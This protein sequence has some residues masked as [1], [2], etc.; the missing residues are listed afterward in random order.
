MRR[1]RAGVLGR[2]VDLQLLAHK[3]DVVEVEQRRGFLHGA[4]FH[5]GKVAGYAGVDDGTAGLK[6]EAHFFHGVAEEVLEDDVSHV[7]ACVAD[8][9][10][11]ALFVYLSVTP[12]RGVFIFVNANVTRLTGHFPLG[13]FVS[14][15]MNLLGAGGC[16]GTEN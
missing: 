11:P 12:R 13:F 6:R 7:G 2:P 4:A 9:Q 10:L 14:Q 3:G 5:E 8:V 15:H 1:L 16:F